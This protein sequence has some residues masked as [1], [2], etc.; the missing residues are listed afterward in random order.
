MHPGIRN[1]NITQPRITSQTHMRTLPF[2]W[3]EFRLWWWRQT[4]A[5]VNLTTFYRIVRD[6]PSEDII[7]DSSKSTPQ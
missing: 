6:L 5:E 1:E 4:Q 7:T 2:P 3:T